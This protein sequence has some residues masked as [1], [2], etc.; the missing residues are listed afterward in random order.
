MPD[1]DASPYAAYVWP[2]FA[3]TAGVFAWMVASSL[4]H[5]RRWKRRAQDRSE[6]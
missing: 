1:F 2:A 5:A 4:G 3:I 6:P